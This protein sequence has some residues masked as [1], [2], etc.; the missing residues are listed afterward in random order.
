MVQMFKNGKYKNA[1]VYI[2]VMPSERMSWDYVKVLNDKKTIYVRALQDFEK[3]YENR[4]PHYWNFSTDG[5]L[6]NLTQQDIY[7]TIVN[8][9]FLN[10]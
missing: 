4:V 3:G 1:K 2:R 7:E 9:D 8:A 10:E 6:Y 5:V